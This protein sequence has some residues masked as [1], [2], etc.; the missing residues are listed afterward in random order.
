MRPGARG[1]ATTWTGPGSDR[2]R[3]RGGELGRNAGREVATLACEIY[4]GRD[5]G[6]AQPAPQPDLRTLRD[7]PRRILSLVHRHRNDTERT[8]KEVPRAAPHRATAV[9]TRPRHAQT[10]RAASIR[11][12]HR[13]P[14]PASLFVKDEATPLGP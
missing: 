6:L 8:T 12:E 13:G 9:C 1:R 11:R 7:R 4:G 3:R 2:D 14:L 10:R 5:L